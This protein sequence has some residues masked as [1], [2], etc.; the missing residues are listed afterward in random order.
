VSAPVIDLLARASEKIAEDVASKWRF[1]SGSQLAEDLPPTPWVCEALA[2]APGAVTVFGGAGFGGKTISLQSMM[3]SVASGLPLWGHF[4]IRQ[5]P[6]KHL[7]WEQGRTLT[8]RRY[9]RLARARGIDLRDLDGALSVSCLPDAW[10]DRDYSEREITHILMGVTV[11]IIDA[12]RGA[13]PS[14]QE[15]DSGV[16]HFLDMLGRVSDRTGCTIIVIAHSRKMS[17]DTDVRSSLRGSGAIFDAAQTVYMLDGAP[18]KPTRIHNTKERVDGEL[19]ESFGLVISDVAGIDDLKWGLSVDYVSPAEVQAAY[20]DT[21]D[22]NAIAMN[23]ERMSSLGAR[24]LPLISA[25]GVPA[26]TIRAML[27]GAAKAS[28]I[29]AVLV[30]LVRQGAVRVEGHGMRAVYTTGLRQPGDD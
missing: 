25:D 9:Q 29:D 26:T 11:A 22:D 10:L 19:R 13:F 1:L 20:L 12:F 2:I 28:D 15:N 23:A 8:Q 7:D 14:A 16:R 27:A 24:M 17:D 30:E 3:L 5:G 21:A 6:V 4:P 18:H